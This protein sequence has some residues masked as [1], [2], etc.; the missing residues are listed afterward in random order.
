MFK[1][2]YRDQLEIEN[3]LR[4]RAG[5]LTMDDFSEI[6]VD[7]EVKTRAVEGSKYFDRRAKDGTLFPKLTCQIAE[8]DPEEKLLIHNYTG[9]CPVET[10]EVN[11]S[12]GCNVGCV[13][14]LV[15]D[16]IHR[17][18]TA[19]QNY[20]ELIANRLE[21]HYE[22]DHFFYFSPKTEA[23][24]E[25]TLETGIA[26]NILKTFLRHY[27]KHPDSRARLFIASKAGREA[28]EYRYDG[29]SIL[30]LFKELRGKMQ[31]NT[32]LSIFPGDARKQIEPYASSLEGRLEAVRLCQE[33]GILS[34][35]ALVQPI[36]VS[37]LSDEILDRFMS[38]LKASGIINIKPEFLTAN[39]E[40]MALLAQ[41]LQPYDKG[42]L[43]KIF[44][45]Y[46]MDDNLD[47][48]KQRGRTAP[49]RELSRFWIEKIIKS[50]SN[51]EISTSICFWVR[52]QLGIG[53][54]EIPVVN[55][56]GFK[57]LGY[58]MRLFER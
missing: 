31:F 32:S 37:V 5:R 46:F 3:D 30:S 35:A 43:K 48:K 58:Q 23:L 8:I 17:P 53:E 15:D 50:A 12:E 45:D 57:C 55:Q 6:A 14:C 29:D 54:D 28:L 11:P 24:C 4:I 16:G 19:Y 42:I 21:E 27:E 7:D 49:K 10:Y 26:H 51:Y 13:Y 47:H 22:T 38:D 44:E 1:P 33:N 39:I 40:N 2:L 41:M 36:L 34:N 56:N 20:H 18:V 9:A 25:A 52:S